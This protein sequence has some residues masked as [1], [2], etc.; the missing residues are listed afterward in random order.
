MLALPQEYINSLCEIKSL[1]NDL[2]AVG[3][4]IKID[5]EALEIAAS[6]GD[7]MLLIEYRLPVKIF[8][9]NSKQGSQVLM[10]ITYLSTE[11]F[12]R[13]EEVRPLQAFERRGAFRVNLNVNGRL[14][15]VL[16]A[17]Q[18][19]EFDQKLAEASPEEVE[20]LLDSSFIEVRI[21]DVSLTGVRLISSTPLHPG[22]NYYIEFTPLEIPMEFCLTVKRVIR[23]LGT[24][25]HYG[26]RFLDFS[27]KQLDILCRD[28]FQLQRLEKNRR[29]NSPTSL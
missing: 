12:M 17:A 2:L 5:D 21:A 19:Q 28:L 8:V 20:K 14:F 9:H 15:P 4:I 25:V 22:E 7:R 10:G 24:E 18:Q 27:E 3:K 29:R 11:N 23:E 26:C 13:A 1:A 16:S 6:E